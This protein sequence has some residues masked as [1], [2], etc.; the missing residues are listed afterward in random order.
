MKDATPDKME[1]HA[2]RFIADVKDFVFLDKDKDKKKDES[3]ED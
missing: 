3:E 2:K 1:D